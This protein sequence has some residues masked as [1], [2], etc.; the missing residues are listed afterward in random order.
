MTPQGHIGS[1][2][3]RLTHIKAEIVLAVLQGLIVGAF[4]ADRWLAATPANFPH[5]L[6][7]EP[8]RWGFVGRE[9]PEHI[10]SQYLRRLSS[11]LD[12][13]T[14]SGQSCEVRVLARSTSSNRISMS[15]RRSKARYVDARIEKHL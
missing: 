15:L 2:S 6:S 14:R 10:A 4:V 9:A 13:K 7:D 11:G 1:I 8:G 12:A 5:T 3:P